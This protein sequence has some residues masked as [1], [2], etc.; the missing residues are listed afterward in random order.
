MADLIFEKQKPYAVIF[1]QIPLKI[2][3]DAE[4]QSEFVSYY[5]Q[6]VHVIS[7]FLTEMKEK[8][9]ISSHVKPESAANVILALTMG[10]RIKTLFLGRDTHEAKM[11]WIETV[12]CI[13]LS[14]PDNV[15]K[16]V[17]S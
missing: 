9:T 16:I 17:Y 8:G 14:A 12:A 1:C 5:D 13:L 11:M 3:I 2:P 7:E 15:S 10:L 6:N 4:Y